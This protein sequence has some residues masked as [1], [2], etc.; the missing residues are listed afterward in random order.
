MV[1]RLIWVHIVLLIIFNTFLS[2]GIMG[3]SIAFLFDSDDPLNGEPQKS[4]LANI[5][6]FS[7]NF[8]G[9]YSLFIIVLSF[10][11][12][13]D[14]EVVYNAFKSPIK[15]EN[16]IEKIIFGGILVAI[17][18]LL[19]YIFY[20]PLFAIVKLFGKFNARYVSLIIIICVDILSF[21]F[22]IISDNRN[23]GLIKGIMVFSIL[24]ITLNIL[25]IIIPNTCW[26]CESD[27][28]DPTIKHKKEE[29]NSSTRINTPPPKPI[30]SPPP[31][32]T[33]SPPPQPTY[34]P[35]PNYIPPHYNP[36]P[37]SLNVNVSISVPVPVVNVHLP[38]P[39]V[40]RPHG[41]PHHYYI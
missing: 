9:L 15:I 17:Y 22:S 40:V 24:Q 34:T 23:V 2:L 16:S 31:Q 35:P 4:R 36:Q 39:V 20:W 32:P 11:F 8:L 28:K 38:H 12:T 6:A 29:E 1:I 30:Y 7:I 21:F 14:G 26:K 27:E 19:V 13:K 37:P 25:S 41:P 10:C 5:I 3:F 18:F 33:Y